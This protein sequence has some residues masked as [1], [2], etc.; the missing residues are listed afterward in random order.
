MNFSRTLY[1]LL[2]LVLLIAV[3]GGLAYLY[4][5][6]SQEPVEPVIE[7][8][9]VE[10]SGKIYLS[11]APLSGTQQI[12]VYDVKGGQLSIMPVADGSNGNTP[13]LNS[14][15][16]EDGK[17]VAF[18][19][20]SGSSPDMLQIATMNADG[21]DVKLITSG[22]SEKKAP[23]WSPDGTKIVYLSSTFDNLR[24]HKDDLWQSEIWDVVVSD[25]LGNSEFITKGTNPKFLSDSSMLV[26]KNDGIHLFDFSQTPYTDS[27]LWPMVAGTTYEG[28]KFSLSSDRTKIAWS[29]PHEEK[30]YIGELRMDPEGL[31]IYH[32]DTLPGL[33]FWPTFS[34]DGHFLVLQT[35]DEGEKATNPRL[36]LYDLTTKELKTILDLKN[37]DPDRLWVNTWRAN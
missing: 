19:T 4:L 21:T 35:I 32:T 33:G 13:K 2:S 24:A 11:L 17:M 12:Y 23:D 16:T 5:F 22:D 27:L 36:V 25:L 9:V 28:M 1:I 7:Q 20:Y 14:D 3:F 6:L 18:S 15:F 29:N 34:P 26:M 8:E 37:Y 31:S 10:P 30:I